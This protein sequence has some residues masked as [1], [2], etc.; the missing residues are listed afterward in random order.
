ME[1][2]LKSASSPFLVAVLLLADPDPLNEDGVAT[3]DL[4]GVLERSFVSLSAAAV[5]ELSVE[6]VVAAVVELSAAVAAVSLLEQPAK[7]K[8]MIL[9]NVI[10]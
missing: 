5:V 9:I 4:A 2:P 10:M 3:D 7:K 8:L 6:V 1:S